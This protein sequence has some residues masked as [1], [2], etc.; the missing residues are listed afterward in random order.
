MIRRIMGIGGFMMMT[1]GMSALDSE[2][3]GYNIAVAI[4]VFGL[5]FLFCWS[6]KGRK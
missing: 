6:S 4:T 2:G 3:T 1:I 5:L